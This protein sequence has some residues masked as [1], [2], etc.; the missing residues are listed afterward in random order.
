MG[1]HIVNS[2]QL[3]FGVRREGNKQQ[4]SAVGVDSGR[5]QSP[6]GDSQ[7][8][9]FTSGYGYLPKASYFFG[10]PTFAGT[11]SKDQPC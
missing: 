4:S 11:Y 7:C 3:V 2:P 5:V 8:P 10:Q 1:K 9:R 6:H